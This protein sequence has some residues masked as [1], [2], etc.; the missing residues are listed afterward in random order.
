MMMAPIALFSYNRPEHTRQTLQTLAA[1]PE[2]AHSRLIVYSDGPRSGDEA[3]VAEVRALLRERA[4][5]GDVRIIE[6]AVNR[7]LAASI[8]HGVTELLREHE[9]LVVLEDDLALSPGFLAYMNRA[10]DLYAAEPRVM[11]ISGWLPEMDLAL[12]E[13]FFLR[14]TTSWGWATWRRAWSSFEPDAAKLCRQVEPRLREFNVEGGYDYFRQ[15]RLNAEGRL[16]TWAVLW[17]A[18]IFL[19]AGLTLHPRRSLVR[20]I[21]HDHSGTHSQPDERFLHASLAQSIPVER[22]PLEPHAAARAAFRKQLRGP[23]RVRFMEGLR[24]SMKTIRRKLR[25]R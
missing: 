25:L 9:R 14:T 22:V 23:L 13:T 3:K 11:S 24:R 5:C 17:Y 20:N 15:L 4:W 6:S 21:G 8:T 16:K 18:S 12:P 10:L 7:G 1:N 2:A 19:Q